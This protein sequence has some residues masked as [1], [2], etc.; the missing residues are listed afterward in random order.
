VLSDRPGRRAALP[1]SSRSLNVTVRAELFDITLFAEAGGP[2]NDAV[3]ADRKLGYIFNRTCKFDIARHNTR[4]ERVDMPHSSRRRQPAEDGG[5]SD[6][7][8][9]KLS[10]M[11]ASEEKLRNKKWQKNQKVRIR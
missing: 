1:N 10:L 3:A 5:P 6:A 7:T 2:M 11:K 9:R 4:K 8:V